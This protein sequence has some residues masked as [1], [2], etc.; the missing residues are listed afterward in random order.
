MAQTRKR[1]P[2]GL[3]LIALIVAV[4]VAFAPA[5]VRAAQTLDA[6]QRADEAALA[7]RVDF[8]ALRADV[9][10]D[11]SAALDAHYAAA[12]ADGTVS[13]L[14]AIIVKPFLEAVISEIVSP[15]GLAKIVKTTLDRDEAPKPF[16]DLVGVALSKGGF[17]GVS[18]FRIALDDDDPK[19]EPT[20]LVFARYGLDWKLAGLDFPPGALKPPT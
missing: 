4:V 8:P 17:A 1:S 7:Q 2:I 16:G 13:S 5:Y 14:A 19:T 9:E 18:T 11:L 20:R 15:A 10:K 3:I 12:G 6:M